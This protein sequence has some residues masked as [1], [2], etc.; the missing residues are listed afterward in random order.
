MLGE[1][2]KRIRSKHTIYKSLRCRRAQY[3]TTPDCFE[4]RL[5]KAFSWMESMTLSLHGSR[6]ATSPLSSYRRGVPTQDPH[7]GKEKGTT[8]GTT[9]SS[10]C[11]SDQEMKTWAFF[12]KIFDFHEIK[13]DEPQFSFSPLEKHHQLFWG[14]GCK[15]QRMCVIQKLQLPSEIYVKRD[16][17]PQGLGCPVPLS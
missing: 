16:S 6:A 17:W 8:V 15:R 5:Q 2:G 11:F 10:Y 4:N 7:G 12:S 3:A 9:P 13:I 14:S 1:R